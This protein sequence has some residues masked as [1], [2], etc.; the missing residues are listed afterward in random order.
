LAAPAARSRFLGSIGNKMLAVLVAVAVLPAVTISIYAL[1]NASDALANQ[2]LTLTKEGCATDARRAESLL[3]SIRQDLGNTIRE[4]GDLNRLLPDLM[5]SGKS[6]TSDER[7]STPPKAWEGIVSD[8]NRIDQRMRS[9][10]NQEPS[11]RGFWVFSLGFS[12]GRLTP[13]LRL[14]RNGDDVV[15]TRCV[16]QDKNNYLRPK[17][18]P[19]D[20]LTQSI[21]RRFEAAREEHPDRDLLRFT[22]QNGD[23]ALEA[24]AGRV[25]E[26]RKQQFES[27]GWVFELHS[28]RA[29]LADLRAASGTNGGGGTVTSLY[30]VKPA[31]G[32][33]RLATSRAATWAE[34]PEEL[35]LAQLAA[36]GT[37]AAALFERGEI[38]TLAFAPFTP[39]REDPSL[40]YVIAIQRPARELME[41]L[42][43]FRLVFT[44]ILAA[45]L[46]LAA[47]VGLLLARRLTRPLRVL[48]DG[49]TQIGRGDLSQTL[50]VHT[51]DEAEELAREFNA[52]ALKL[53][54]LYQGMETTITERTEQLQRALD[55]LRRA[56]TNLVESERRYSDIVENASDLIQVTDAE[57]RILSANRRQAELLGVPADEIKGRDFFEFVAADVRDATKRAFAYVLGGHSLQAFES[58]LGVG[59]QTIPVEIS[60]TPV[61]DGEKPIGVRA[62]LRD[63]GERKV[64][65]ARVIK[66]ERL[67]SVGALAA[68]VAHEINNP[69]GIINLFAQR[70]LEKAKKGE[71]DV[72]KLEKIVEQGRRVAAI[73]RNLLDFAR[74]APTRFAPFD[75]GEVLRST[76][77][78]VSDR[79]R[80]GEIELVQEIATGLPRI[81][82]NGQ[83]ISQVVLNLLLNAV[84]A[85]GRGGRIVVR[86]ADTPTSRLPT[87]GRAVRVT[88]EDSG[89]GIPPDAL[90]RLFEPFFTTKAP[91]EGT[92]LGLSVSW[93][94]L[95]E[96]H[97]S[98]FAS[99]RPEGGARFEF[100]LPVEGETSHAAPAPA[101]PGRRA[102][103]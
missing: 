17:A 49:A 19:A 87:A 11:C 82:G 63:V 91:G 84:Q 41:N 27:V 60:A 73:T 88:V 90:P 30:E 68:G 39:R 12:Y 28:W 18:E 55:D 59:A 15:T 52:M 10:F 29:I 62:I 26:M 61:L 5:H 43:Q 71:I 3:D 8:V 45:A 25:Q 48:R 53:R 50:E 46:L 22:V 97:G 21:L 93:G 78:L 57:G 86:A 100:E 16:Q 64:M 24:F 38:E 34:I 66:A 14:D 92:G 13:V 56:H 9:I 102:E 20:P 96:H 80:V 85:I 6:P 31:V 76:C 7:D 89:P 103:G 94:I 81:V 79:A 99:N 42:K 40:R 101:V 36:A 4:N 32:L 69:L 58:A 54:S 65:E 35:D 47:L 1:R 51:G 67:S 72:D 23:D 95:K 44:T 75:V 2:A 33:A 70:M 83:Q 98:I 37:A 74:A 77:S